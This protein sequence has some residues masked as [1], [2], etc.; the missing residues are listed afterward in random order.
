MIIAIANQKGG[1]GKTTTAANLA[2]ALAGHGQRVLA[3]DLD[4]QG[5]LTFW[6]GQDETALEE[7]RRTIY[8]AIVGDTALEELVLPGAFDLI[9]AGI[10]L[11]KAEAELLSEPNGSLVLKEL[12][13]V[14]SERY[15]TILIDCPP[16]LGMLT[17]NALNA[18]H[19]VIIPVKTQLL[20]LIGLTQILETIRKV[21]RRAN[22]QLRIVGIVPTMHHAR[23]AHDGEVL[24]E[25]RE[26]Y[27]E[28]RIFEPIPNTTRL[29]RV[30]GGED[31]G[32]LPPP[33]EAYA[34]IAAA[35]S[36]DERGGEHG[37]GA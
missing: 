12:L 20:S 2:L 8:H 37:Q 3:L 24:R 6:C 9:P 21:R 19:G 31:G 34:R 13:A 11:A 23:H 22:P 29:A 16:S 25:I 4:P 36:G 27:H 33:H 18:A 15:D 1:V 30:T 35:L 26:H 5:S 32:P 10:S 7:A 17:V 14:A 28:L